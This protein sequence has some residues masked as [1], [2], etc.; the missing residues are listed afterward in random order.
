MSKFHPSTPEQYKPILE[1]L[2]KKY[3]IDTY[4][5]SSQINHE[6]GWNPAARGN[7][8]TSYDRGLAQINN[9]WHPEI[10]D[11]QA[12]NPQFA[13]DWMAKTM[14]EKKNRLGDWGKALSEYNTG[15]P[16]DGFKNGYV[17]RILGG[18][19]PLSENSY[20]SNKQ[21]TQISGQAQEQPTQNLFDSLRKLF[22]PQQPQQAT[23][24]PYL[25]PIPSYQSS[26]AQPLQVPIMPTMPSNKQASDIFYQGT[27]KPASV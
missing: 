13:L 2:S 4:V 17:S 3:G 1:A 27:Q 12:D 11:S 25:S 26:P 6:S 20:S 8:G 15:N 9:Y 5:L 7:N 10:T 21:S 16:N 23:P 24:P 19:S 22:Q 14:A 18:Q